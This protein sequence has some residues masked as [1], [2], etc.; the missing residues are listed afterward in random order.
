MTEQEQIVF[1]NKQLEKIIIN[2]EQIASGLY[3]KNGCMEIASLTL[4]AITISRSLK[5]NEQN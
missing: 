5:I 4:E 3:D 2:L 1:L